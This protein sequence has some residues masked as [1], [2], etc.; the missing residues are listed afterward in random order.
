ML[1]EPT[2]KQ[3]KNIDSVK[4]LTNSDMQIIN[5]AFADLDECEMERDSL[6]K[7]IQLQ[8]EMIKSKGELISVYQ[9]QA[10]ILIPLKEEIQQSLDIM[11]MR[12][13]LLEGMYKSLDKKVN[14]FW[15]QMKGLGIKIGVPVGTVVFTTVMVSLLKTF[16]IF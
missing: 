11:N 6:C 15:G 16:K 5:G 10:D 12:Y 9:K 1:S 8:D 13:N 2:S 3:E 4:C 7:K 14:G